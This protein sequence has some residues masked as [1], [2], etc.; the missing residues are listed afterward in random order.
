MEARAP[1]ACFNGRL[2]GRR[3]PTHLEQARLAEGRRRKRPWIPDDGSR[4]EDE[5][6]KGDGR[7]AGSACAQGSGTSDIV[8]EC[9]QSRQAQ[10][11]AITGARQDRG[12]VSIEH[13]PL[14]SELR[15]AASAASPNTAPS[16]GTAL[17]WFALATL[18]SSDR[19]MVAPDKMRVPCGMDVSHEGAL[20]LLIAN[21]VCC[22]PMWCCCLRITSDG[23]RP[24]EGTTR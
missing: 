9:R 6:G 12:I 20:M 23:G 2:S 21:A 17:L 19:T 15:P 10:E 7:V 5:P 11:R 1:G 22:L 14:C 4:D 18:S 3:G 24:A 13:P 16:P 8:C